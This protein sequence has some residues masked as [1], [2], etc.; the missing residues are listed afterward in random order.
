MLSDAVAAYLESVSERAFDEPLMALLRVRGFTSVRLV[1]G[2]REFGKDVIARRDGEQWGFQS[3]A[4]DIGQSEWRALTGQLDELRVVNLGH[5]A[6]NTD[7][8]R[9]PVLVTTGRLVG[10]APEL[11]GDYN[12]RA[13]ERGEPKL[14]LWDR[15][16][17]L[18]QLAGDPESALSG[19]MDGQLMSILGAA[20]ARSVTMPEL[21]VFSRRWMAWE[22]DRLAGLGVIEAALVSE[23]LRGVDRLDL[24]C[25]LAL[26]LVRAV[27]ASGAT[28]LPDDTS[29]PAARSLF[30]AYARAL[31]EKCGD[32]LLE[33]PLL[34]HV[35]FGGWVTYPVRCVRLAEIL[36]LLALLVKESDPELSQE[37][38]LWLVTLCE[39]QPG[40]AHPISDQYA[41][42]V[43]PAV[44]A[45]ATVDQ[46]AAKTHLKRCTVWL[47]DRYERDE[48]GLAREDAS[49]DEEVEYLI[50]GPFESV[51]VERRLDSLVAP[52][53]L[54]L[55][56]ALGF[57]D[58][59]GD[60]HNDLQ[61]VRIHPQV[62]RLADGPD[63][64]SRAGSANR[65][66]PNVDFTES[67][68]DEVLA[69]HH[70]D[71][72]GES[73]VASGHAWDLLATGSAL[74]DRYYVR[75]LAS[76]AA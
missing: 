60:I 44:L 26:C 14:E 10:N 29:A 54:D 61:A 15:D 35:E 71:R 68:A 34:N 72:A 50:G 28:S 33:H 53:L 1:H 31:W 55:T 75:A 56:A 41:V 27:W 16:I 42:S 43:I 3:K 52:V 11:Y 51:Q 40:V 45:L 5:G 12:K 70:N 8:P 65:I 7:L 46:D 49:P 57:S 17:L 9:R 47:C 13:D 66:D 30:E 63:Q 64:Y 67:L 21:E 4:G 18:G 32:E 2:A 69:P 62:L 25:H 38:S 48:L 73:Q 74:R 19:S 58:L 76:L 20:E 37:I 6:F 36:G 22:P 24:A 59:Y 39:K 23:R